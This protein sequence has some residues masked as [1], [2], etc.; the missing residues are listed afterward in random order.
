MSSVTFP[1]VCFH[2]YIVLE[3]YPIVINQARIEETQ[4]SYLIS[5]LYLF[6]SSYRFSFSKLQGLFI[7]WT[8]GKLSLDSFL[9]YEISSCF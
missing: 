8:H 6:E 5:K 2:S 1:V 4:F 7:Y 9:F 3:S